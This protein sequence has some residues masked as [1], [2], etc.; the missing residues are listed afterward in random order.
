MDSQIEMSALMDSA[1]GS[2]MVVNAMSSSADAVQPSK[3][4]HCESPNKSPKAVRRAKKSPNPVRA[5]NQ[6]PR[7]VNVADGVTT[8]YSVR[9]PPAWHRG[10]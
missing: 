1:V 2:M 5:K 4:V 7:Y 8:P 6:K 10:W 9:C 3:I